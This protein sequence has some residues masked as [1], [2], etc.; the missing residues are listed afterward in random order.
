MDRTGEE[1]S[2]VAHSTAFRIMKRSLVFV[3]DN[4]LV[5]G[6]GIAAVLGYFFPRTSIP[7]QRCA[8]AKPACVDVAARGGIIKSEYSVLYGAIALIFLINGAQLSPEKLK[9]HATNWRLHIVV[10]V[11]NLILIPVIQISR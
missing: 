8:L 7:R 1:Q 3:L 4:W 5:I 11:I 10:Q 6:F 9:Q 2:P